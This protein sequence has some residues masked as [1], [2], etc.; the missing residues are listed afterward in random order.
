MDSLDVYMKKKEERR[1]KLMTPAK[2]ASAAKVCMQETRLHNTAFERGDHLPGKPRTVWKFDGCRGNVRQLTKIGEMS[3]R[4]SFCSD[5]I[6]TGSIVKKSVLEV[7]NCPL[8]TLL[9]VRRFW[10]F[11]CDIVKYR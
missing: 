1:R 4:K 9:W 7:G 2:L 10:A 11:C 3:G 5:I 8:I 6:V